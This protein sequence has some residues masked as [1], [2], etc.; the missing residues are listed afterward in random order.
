MLERYHAIRPVAAIW[1][2][3]ASSIMPSFAKG[4]YSDLVKFVLENED[5]R[6]DVIDL[7]FI[8]VTH[9]FDATPEGNYVV[10]K[11]DDTV[12]SLTPNGDRPG[13]ADISAGN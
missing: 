4:H 13:L 5:S 2:I 9:N 12:Y 6:M 3:S 11:I 8:L 7:A 10:V 1:I